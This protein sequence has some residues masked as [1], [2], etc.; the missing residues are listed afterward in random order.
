MKSSRSQKNNTSRK[1]DVKKSPQAATSDC[2][3]RGPLTLEQHEHLR[4]QVV[5]ARNELGAKTI[6]FSILAECR[7][8]SDELSS[9]RA[10]KVAFDLTREEVAH[11]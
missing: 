1:A 4:R 2:S 9:V 10:G 11:V 6:A 8:L 3:T 5:F 7:R